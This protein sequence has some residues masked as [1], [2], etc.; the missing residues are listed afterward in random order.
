[1]KVIALYEFN[2]QPNSGEITIHKDEIITGE[3]YN[4]MMCFNF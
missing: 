4:T 3:F 2:A 1:M